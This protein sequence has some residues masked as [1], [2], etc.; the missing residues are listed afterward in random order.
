MREVMIAAVVLAAGV[1]SRM[2]KPKQTLPLDGVPMLERV[3]EIFRRS[4]VDKVV[5]V[6]GAD[7][8]EVKKRVKFGEELVVVNSG[9]AEG[10]SSSLKL[11]LKHVG[12][13]AE[14]VIIALG[15][16][17]F[18]L[19]TTIDMLVAAYKGSRARIVVPTY[20]GARGNP[21]LFDRGVFPQMAT[22]R[23]DIGAKSVVQKNAA[24]VL[25][26]EVPDMGVLV[27]IDTPSDL[28]RRM[29]VRRKRSRARA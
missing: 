25:E 14:A 8:V 17:P 21:V 23:G 20:R 27:D 28:D 3:L 7:A 10:M 13:E 19:P 2:G 12:R 5:V 6:L 26:V 18:V 22:I 1:S 9:F 15:D 11:G 24:D 29:K 16:Q 4:N